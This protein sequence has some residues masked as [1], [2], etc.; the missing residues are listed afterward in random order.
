MRRALHKLLN[1]LRTEHAEPVR[2]GAAV[3]VGVFLGTLPLYGIHL[4]LCLLAA[5]AL[6]LNRVTV[7]LAANI[8]N[9]LLAPFLVAGGLY[10]GE[11][12]RFGEMRPWDLDAAHS[13]L[14]GLSWLGGELPDRFLSCLIGDA[15]LG[16]GLGLLAAPTATLIARRLQ[17]TTAPE[18]PV[19]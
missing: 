8:S 9:P 12:L 17:A 5:W 7:Y 3:G 19:E 4:A 11:W 14:E 18:A 6:R 13:L 1:H 15:V 16:L 2:L 10:I